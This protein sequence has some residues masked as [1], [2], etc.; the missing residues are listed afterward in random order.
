MAW[1]TRPPTW[2]DLILPSEA[3]AAGPAADELIAA[4]FFDGRSSQPVP[5]LMRLIQ[6][7]GKGGVALQLYLPATTAGSVAA[8]SLSS[9]PSASSAPWREFTANQIEWPDAG[10]TRIAVIRFADGSQAQ[11]LEPQRLTAA[12]R[13]AGYRAPGLHALASKMAS[14]RGALLAGVVAC[15]AISAGVWLYGVPALSKVITHFMP[16]RW[17]TQLADRTLDVLD[18]SW[19]KPS[20]LSADRQTQI[21]AEFDAL[22]KKAAPG[23]A[24]PRYRLLFRSMAPI[25]KTA[26]GGAGSGANA[27]ALP[28]GVL[29]M[30]DELVT[31]AEPSAILGVLAHE[32]G[33]VNHRHATRVAVESSLLGTA[34][35]LISG[36]PTSVIATVPVALASLSFSRSH[37]T[38]ADCYALQMMARAGQ[39][40]EPLAKLLETISRGQSGTGGGMAGVLSSHPSTPARVQLLR[41]PAA[42]RQVC[43]G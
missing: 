2:P 39:S 3:P 37:E 9:A 6:A 4:R 13:A 43:S 32:L 10:E 1:E 26:E 23:G 29:V 28:G 7:P 42:L 34:I 8:P 14:H 27:F 5:C 11:T 31:V 38:E 16:T 21:T 22:V 24:A 12:L 25:G 19:L 40:T 36:D 18:K 35:A 20:A 15:A 33:H 41:D 30:T 17:E